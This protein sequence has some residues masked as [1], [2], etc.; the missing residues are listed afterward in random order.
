MLKLILCLLTCFSVA[1]VTLQMRQQRLE[2]QYLANS[3]H[4]DM[5]LLQARLW[6]QQRQIAEFTAPNAIAKTVGLNSLNMVPQ[7]P[8]P[9]NK[10]NWTD[11]TDNPDAE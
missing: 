4:N 2:L 5:E 9:S 7:T 8:L 3:R 11:A 1:V 6:N 10:T